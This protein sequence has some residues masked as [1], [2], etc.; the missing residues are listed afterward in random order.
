VVEISDAGGYDRL[1][2]EALNADGLATPN[3]QGASRDGSDL[4]LNVSITSSIDGI[5]NS[6][7]Q[8]RVANYYTQNG[9]I[10]TIEFPFGVL[11]AGFN[12]LPQVND[13]AIDQVIE[14]D[15][16]YSYQLDAGT[17]TDN[18]VI[19][20]LEVRATRSDGSDLPNWL[21]FDA[22]TLTFG[23]TPTAADSEILDIK[24]IATDRRN[25]SVSLDFNLNVGNINV[26]P[27]AAAPI[28]TQ[29]AR[30][31]RVFDF[32]IPASSFVGVNLNEIINHTWRQ[33]A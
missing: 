11:G 29:V 22:D 32:Q 12:N 26:A 23:G 27:Q 19:D 17:F 8:V 1:S 28:E 14:S 18:D 2:F 21:S 7:G 6:T 31:Q 24:V 10:E 3:Y 4:V 16:A 15:V 20:V 9:H 25:E 5:S 30:S 13:S 33:A